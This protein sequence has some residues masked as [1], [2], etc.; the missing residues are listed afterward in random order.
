MLLDRTAAGANA[1]RRPAACAVRRA[2]LRA[3]NR[4]A[5][6]PATLDRAGP[7]TLSAVYNVQNPAF[8]ERVRQIWDAPFIAHLGMTLVRVEPGCCASELTP[9][10]E[11]LQQD[12]V[13]HAGVVSTLADHTAGAAAA[14]LMAAPQLVLTS[15]FKIHLLRPARGPLACLATVLKPGRT[16]SIVEAEVRATDTLVAK[17]IGTLVIVDRVG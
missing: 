8:V 11:H 6:L 15:E 16:F 17:F 5:A 10:P 9:R 2:D 13:V 7:G 14:T 12:G 1:S 4:R 3:A